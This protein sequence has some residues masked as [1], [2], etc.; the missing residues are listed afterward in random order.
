MGNASSHRGA[1]RPRQPASV[2][3]R[4]AWAMRGCTAASLPCSRERGLAPRGRSRPFTGALS[5]LAYQPGQDQLPGS[6][7]VSVPRGS[8][9]GLVHPLGKWVTSPRGSDVGLLALLLVRSRLPA[10]WLCAGPVSA[11]EVPLPVP[12]MPS[13]PL[14]SCFFP[15]FLP[16]G[17]P[18]LHACEY[19]GCPAL[20][21]THVSALVTVGFCAAWLSPGLW[22]PPPPSVGPGQSRQR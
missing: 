21:G 7:A 6:R 18:L 3:P 4:K 10:S 15:F 2:L 11:G 5:P 16:H 22:P 9:R 20:S 14:R 17:D 13:V 12:A 8:A 1:G 19:W